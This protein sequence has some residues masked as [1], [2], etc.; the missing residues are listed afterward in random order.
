MHIHLNRDLKPEN[1]LICDDGHIKLADFGL[2]KLSVPY[3]VDSKSF[4]GSPAYM[5]PETLLK[6]KVG[7]YVDY[8]ALGT[9]FEYRRYRTF[10]T[11][12]WPTTIYRQ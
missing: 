1:I 10:R 7:K 2:S 9:E 12:N 11:S 4:C 8:Y 6:V 3:E 5:S